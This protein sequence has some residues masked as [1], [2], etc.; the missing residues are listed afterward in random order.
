MTAVAAVP[1]FAV[2][3]AV[4]QPCGIVSG[5]W[6]FR[7]VDR[8]PRLAVC[9]CGLCSLIHLMICAFAF[10]LLEAASAGAG[11]EDGAEEGSGER[12]FAQGE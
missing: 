9:L 7:W 1:A 2:P 3:A 12:Q 10:G 8:V 5:C 6:L 11:R 4:A